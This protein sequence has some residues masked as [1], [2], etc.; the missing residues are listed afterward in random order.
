MQVKMVHLY[1]FVGAL[2]VGLAVAAAAKAQAQQRELNF[3]NWS[4]YIAEDTLTN[5]EQRTGIKVNYVEFDD[6]EELEEM[7]LKE[8]RSFD[9]IVPG[10]DNIPYYIQRGAISKLDPERIRGWKRNDPAFMERLRNFDP[11]NE[12]AFP[13]LWGTVGIGYNVEKVRE[14]FGG[15]LPPDSWDLLFDPENLGKLA[16]CGAT[17]MRSPEE[18]FDVGLKYIGK[19]P[20]DFGR[21]AQ[22]QVGSL[23][24]KVRLHITDFDSGEYVEELISG[25]RCIA[26]GWSGDILEAQERAKEAGKSH[27]IRYIMPEEGFPLWVDVVSMPTNARNVDEAYEFMSYL[28][29]PEVIAEISNEMHY[30]NA[31]LEAEPFVAPEL[32][33]NPIVY[34]DEATLANT[35]I[36]LATPRPINDLRQRL[37]LR[38]IER[39]K[40]F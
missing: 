32:L 24:A 19:D 7:W 13:F 27:N 34:P 11:A 15:T 17:L 22:R 9:V 18:I 28:M 3:A 14:A 29:E 30:A 12:Y 16:S 23:L 36:P 35:W 38:L 1:Q 6:I 21:G 40:I 31:N 37:W 2:I 4:E 26:H 25:K 20:N 39:E 10:S 8:G 5:F 33:R